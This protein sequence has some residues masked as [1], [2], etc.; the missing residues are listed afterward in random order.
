MHGMERRVWR[1]VVGCGAAH[2]GG[3]G[4]AWPGVARQGAAWTGLAGD[5]RIGGSPMACSGEAGKARNGIVCHGAASCGVA[6]QARNGS[7]SRALG[8]AWQARMARLGTEG[9]ARPG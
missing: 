4:P 3:L 8:E 2:H 9:T 5:L 1:G 6:G 7:T